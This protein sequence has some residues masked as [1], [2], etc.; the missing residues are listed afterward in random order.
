MPTPDIDLTVYPDDCD[1]FG[2]LNQAAFL[3]LFE[4]ARWE[5]FARGPGMDV[6]TR[7]NAWPAVR[8]TTIDYHAPAFPGDVLRFQQ[9]L[10]H[11][12]QTS[13]TMRQTARRAGDDSLIATAEFV[14]VCINREG[15]PV[16]VPVEVARFMNARP[17]SRGEMARLTVNGVNLA[18]DIR[19]DGPAILFVHGY[20]LDRTI[21]QHQVGALTGWRRI[22]PDLRGFGL[23]D[24]PDLG[25]SMATWADDL[26]AL[27]D[28]LGVEQAVLCGHS[29]G[30][31]IGFEFARRYRARLRA[32][33]LVDSRAESDT[34]DGKRAREAA[35]VVAR[36]QGPRAIAAQML[37]KMLAAGAAQTM[38]Q[39]ADR[40]R[41]IMES[42][43]LSGILGALGAMRD[44]PDSTPLLAELSGIPTLAIVGEQDELTPAAMSRAIVD[45]IPG[46]VLGVI[47]NAG[48]LPPVEQPLATTRVLGEFLDS[49]H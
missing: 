36:E 11:H 45:R 10:T 31:Y 6:F 38:P 49:L 9:A 17:S 42:A 13:F 48:H 16:P 23:S 27:L 35:M 46:A 7:G 2:H 41:G 26:A 33:V 34:A 5:M 43:P 39:V 14:F 3:S 44:R 32:L 12:G 15:R 30:G 4:R 37:P 20:P 19:G 18:V 25:Y 40:V 29:M 1:A 22:A 24:A 47:P 28:A 8:K 21:W